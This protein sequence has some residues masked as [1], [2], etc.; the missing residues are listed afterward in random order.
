MFI[1]GLWENMSLE[2]SMDSRVAHCRGFDIGIVDST[3]GEA[4][5]RGARNL[6]QF[7][8]DSLVWTFYA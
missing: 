7:G 1:G 2:T 6:R 5:L 3:F 4:I 8:V